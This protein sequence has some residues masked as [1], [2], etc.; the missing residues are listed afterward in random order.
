MINFLK[1]YDSG[2]KD[3]L[4]T[5]RPFG[6]KNLK[7][8]IHDA[9]FTYSIANPSLTCSDLC[10]NSLILQKSYNIKVKNRKSRLPP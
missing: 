3:T 10:L 4:P 1:S 5:K 2:I 8:H 7:T 9:N 6:L